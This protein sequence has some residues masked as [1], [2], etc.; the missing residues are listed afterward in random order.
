MKVSSYNYV[1]YDSNC[2]YWFNGLNNTHFKLTLQLSKK[3]EQL[4][5]DPQLLSKML[6][7]LSAKLESNGFLIED[8]INEIDIIRTKYN[9]SVNSPYYSITVLPTLNC[10][11]K[12]WYCIQN[13]IPSIMAEE[14]MQ[15]IKK[16]IVYMIEVQ[17]IKS[18]HLDWFGGEPFMFYSKVVKPLSLFA[19]SFCKEKNVDF[20]LGTTT[21]GYYINKKVGQELTE[22]GFSTFQITLDGNKEFHDK[23]KF[24]NGCVSAFDTVLK[25]ID[26]LIDSN[27]NVNIALRINY[28]NNNVTDSIVNQINTHINPKHRANIIVCPHKVWQETPNPDFKKSI[29]SI[30]DLFDKAGYRTQR[31]NPS[32]GFV[33]CYAS[34]KYF[35]TINYNGD[36][37]K[38][39]AC[40][41]LYAKTPRGAILNDGSLKWNDDFDK[42]YQEASFENERCLNCKSLPLCMGLCPRD[43]YNGR[44]HCKYDGEDETLESS[45]FER[46]KQVYRHE[47]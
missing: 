27:S 32:T 22:L 45:I 15:K 26:N 13:H 20:S 2:G 41:D 30:L 3:I 8:D 35:T 38:C 12:C 39:T 1:F 19:K 21:N 6:P 11:F 17:K 40:D 4:M 25:N 37:L 42:K 29:N 24:Q 23:V 7:D 14:T 16:H 47:K 18:L 10:N 33:P 44:S 28:S 5:T 31:W 36:I 34:R 9:E 43:H 46:L